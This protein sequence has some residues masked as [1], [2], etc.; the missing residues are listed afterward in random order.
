M[1]SFLKIQHKT[2]LILDPS[3]PGIDLDQFKREDWSTTPYGDGAGGCRKFKKIPLTLRIELLDNKINPPKIPF[4]G[5]CFSSK[6]QCI[7]LHTIL[8]FVYRN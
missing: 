8:F 6:S 3:E 1:F 2:E 5:T 4:S 7:P